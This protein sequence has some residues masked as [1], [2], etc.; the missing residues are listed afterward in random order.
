VAAKRHG[1]R[2]ILDGAPNNPH[3]VAPLRGQFRPD[4][5]RPV[6]EPGDCIE[7]LEEARKAA[8][9]HPTAIKL[10]EIAPGDVA[11]A[12]AQAKADDEASREGLAAAKLDGRANDDNSRFDD[13]QKAVK[14]SKE[15]D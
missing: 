6:G 1:I 15:T 5:P 12:E 9:D 10:V 13:E 14:A 7:D 2:L 11:K 4:P 8:N 3:T